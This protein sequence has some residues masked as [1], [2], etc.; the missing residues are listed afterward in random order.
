MEQDM[1]ADDFWKHVKA[2]AKSRGLT[3]ARLAGACDIPYGKLQG[4]IHRSVLP[5]VF[6]AFRIAKALG[7]TVESLVTGR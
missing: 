2:D 4:W 6:S 7:T 3:L 1:N 5:D